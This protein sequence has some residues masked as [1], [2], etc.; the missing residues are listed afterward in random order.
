MKKRGDNVGGVSW[1]YG[2]IPLPNMAIHR[3]TEKK[4]YIM[5][6]V[7]ALVLVVAYI[8]ALV[9]VVVMALCT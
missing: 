2:I 9:V 3:H 1:Q 5:A 4:Q 6:V 8:M 7:M